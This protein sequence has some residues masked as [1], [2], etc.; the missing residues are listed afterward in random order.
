[1][2][3]VPYVHRFGRLSCVALPLLLAG[4]AAASNQGAPMRPERSEIHVHYDRS[5]LTSAVGAR[6]LLSRIGN[7]ALESC[8]ASAFSLPE[9]R[10]ATMASQCFKDAVND[11]VRRID[12]PLLN[13]AAG[14]DR[15]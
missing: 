2:N 12:S 7:A 8:G 14:G 9:L 1:M 13:A 11:A 4:I 10:N 5:T 15:H 3:T 6:R